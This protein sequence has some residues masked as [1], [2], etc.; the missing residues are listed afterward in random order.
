MKVSNKTK[1]NN[2]DD[3]SEQKRKLISFGLQIAAASYEG[4]LFGWDTE[5]EKGK[6]IFPPPHPF[7]QNLKV[8]WLY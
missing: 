3:Q 7:S 6:N 8:S 1:P 2:D 5:E 4:S